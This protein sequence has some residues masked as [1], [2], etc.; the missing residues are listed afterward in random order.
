MLIQKVHHVAYRCLD[1]KQ[2]VEWYEKHLGMKFVL[3]IAENLVRFENGKT[4]VEVETTP[5]HFEK[6]EVKLGLSDS[7]DV[8]VKSGIDVRATL[9]VQDGIDPAPPAKK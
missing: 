2:T 7:I 5:G 9:K 8:E 3:A 6:R 1:A 4:F